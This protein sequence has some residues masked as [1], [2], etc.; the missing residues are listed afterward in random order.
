MRSNAPCGHCGLH[1]RLAGVQ[2]RSTTAGGP[3][4]QILL[5]ER[6][7]TEPQRVAL[8]RARYAPVRTLNRDPR[9]A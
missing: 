4:E 8:W 1:G 6:C 9:E 3:T 7:R 5:C 2:V